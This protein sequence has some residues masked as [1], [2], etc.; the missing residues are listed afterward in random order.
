MERVGM[1]MV[2]E[3]ILSRL[4]SKVVGRFRCVCKQWRYEAS[5]HMFAI[6]HARRMANSQN[7]KLITFTNLSVV[8]D[9]VVGGKIDFFARKNI[10]FPIFTCPLFLNI[11]ASLYGLLLISTKHPSNK[12]ILWNPTT[13]RYLF[14]LHENSD[15]IYLNSADTA[16]MYLDA[17][18]DL[19]ILHIKRRNDVVVSRVYSR[20]SGTWR[21]I[22]FLKGTPLGSR[23]YTW[24]VGTLSNNKLYFTVFHYWL[25]DYL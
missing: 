18:N 6:V 8:I 25:C 9:N 16:G 7:R 23:I 24:S 13:A 5:T 22:D 3:E 14:L 1:E 19:K 15:S 21:T 4:P 17:S 12:L 11:I 2:V 10:S 20:C